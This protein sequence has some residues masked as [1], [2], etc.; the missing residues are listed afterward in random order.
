MY[1]LNVV[2]V[3]MHIT[4]YIRPMSELMRCEV[5]CESVTSLGG[6]AA[7]KREIIRLALGAGLSAI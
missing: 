3:Y 6:A 7:F 2:Y 5:S 1:M 4:I